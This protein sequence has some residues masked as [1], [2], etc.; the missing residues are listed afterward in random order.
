VTGE[1]LIDLLAAELQEP[2]PDGA[3]ALAAQLA[4]RGG[5][6]VAA[7]LYYGSTLR[8]ASL[9]GILDFYVLVDRVSA[10]PGSAWAHLAN[11]VLPPNVGY[12]DLAHEGAV[13]RAK[14]AVMTPA[15]FQARVGE[16]SRDTTIWARFCQ[17]ALCI[18][19]RSTADR[20]AATELVAGAVTR[21]AW[22]AAHLGPVS[23]SAGEYWRA[24]FTHTYAAEL[25]VEKTGRAQDIVARHEERYAR[26]LPLAW[27]RGRLGNARRDDGT[28]EPF[29]TASE[30]RRAARLWKTLAR[31]GRQLNML[32]LLKAALTFDGA[33]DY[34]VWKIER[35]RGVRLE[36]KPWERR[37]PLLAAPGIY[38]RLRRLGVIRSRAP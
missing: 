3:M 34:V 13:L 5:H 23:G 14:Y 20:T 9:D 28:L 6:A 12:P 19:T 2:A 33:L 26:L 4:Q 8:A 22:W 11:R 30:R 36:V 38:W 24:L 16:R 21:A 1:S 35:H 15:Q 29:I 32:R 17:P 7:V 18:W 27:S 31:R 37:F 10:W 25:R